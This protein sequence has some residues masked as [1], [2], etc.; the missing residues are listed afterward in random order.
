MTL[1]ELCDKFR[2]TLII[3]RLPEKPGKSQVRYSAQLQ[4]TILQTSLPRL[5][6]DSKKR[7][8]ATH[9][10]INKALYNLCEKISNQYVVS[11]HKGCKVG[12]IEKGNLAIVG[13]W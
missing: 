10:D 4:N 5:W 12:E 13:V 11:S 3:K 8:C 7:A 1:L 9:E 2:T 6:G